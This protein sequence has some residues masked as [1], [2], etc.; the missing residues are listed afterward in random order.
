MNLANPP[1][2]VLFAIGLWIGVN[3][4]IGLISGWAELARAYRF[5]GKFSGV[6][7]RF[8]S[9]QMRLLM[10]F[11][12]AVTVGSSP[13]GLYLS[14]F[15]PF[16]PGKAPVLIPW[17]DVSA[18]PGKFWFWRYTEF[19]FRQ[20]PAVFLQL[21]LSLGSKVRAAAGP[22]WPAALVGGDEPF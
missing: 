15:F 18:R 8:Q 11:R 5:R 22:A 12:N 7:W 13:E 6:R 3:Y 9:G 14:P 4:F 17:N 20:A 16:R 2:F 1:Q 10:G 21:P 19:R